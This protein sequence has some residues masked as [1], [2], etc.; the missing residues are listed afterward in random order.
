[1]KW[2]VLSDA[3]ISEVSGAG[4]T[5]RILLAS[6]LTCPECPNDSDRHEHIAYGCRDIL[7]R[8]EDLVCE[9]VQA[10]PLK[11][12]VSHWAPGSI[13]VRKPWLRI[14]GDSTGC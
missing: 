12:Q 4:Q 10:D 14:S 11:N 2:S 6:I 8:N 5:I 9:S 13:I 3:S 1:M 7:C